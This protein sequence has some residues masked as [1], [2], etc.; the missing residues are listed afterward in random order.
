V[1][2]WC[3]G[4]LHRHPSE[5]GTASNKRQ[6]LN[7]GNRERDSPLRVEKILP[8]LVGCQLTL[9]RTDG[10]WQSEAISALA[11]SVTRTGGWQTATAAKQAKSGSADGEGQRGQRERGREQDEKAGAV[12]SC[13]GKAEKSAQSKF[14]GTPEL[15]PSSRRASSAICSLPVTRKPARRF[16][17]TYARRV[18][19]TF[20]GSYKNL[21]AAAFRRFYHSL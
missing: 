3:A 8:G 21:R 11:G 10:R 7:S 15:L 13:R 16:T 2:R 12:R 20:V 6:K 14:M 19:Q 4:G 5:D 1:Q 18:A 17:S 9:A